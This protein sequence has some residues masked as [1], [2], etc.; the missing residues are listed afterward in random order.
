MKIR[1]KKIKTLVTLCLGVLV[2]DL[3]FFAGCGKPLASARVVPDVAYVSKSFTTDQTSALAA[4]RWALKIRG[5][6]IAGEKPGEGIITTTWLPTTSDS[7]MID[8]FN[9]HDFGVNGAYHQLMVQVSGESGRTQVSVG[10]RVKTLVSNL[11]SSGIEERRVLSEVGNY[12]RMSEPNLT[13]IGLE[14]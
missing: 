13:N 11:K 5:Y 7:H 2:V 8:L 4:V 3:L 6:S 12:L 10:S 9:R 1:K 14:E